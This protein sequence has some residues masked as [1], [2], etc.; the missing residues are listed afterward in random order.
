ME[1]TSQLEK[2]GYPTKE[3]GFGVVGSLNLVKDGYK[4]E[5]RTTC[6][7]KKGTIDGKINC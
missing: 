7:R 1:P 2:K 3:V 6:T 4:K 5:Q